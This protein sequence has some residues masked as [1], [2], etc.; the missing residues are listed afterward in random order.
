MTIGSA[1]VE[2]HTYTYSRYQL[3]IEL[4][5]HLDLLICDIRRRQRCCYTWMRIN[6]YVLC[7]CSGVSGYDNN[8]KPC[9]RHIHTHKNMARGTGKHW[10]KTDKLE[11]NSI[12][13]VAELCVFFR[14][15]ILDSKWTLHVSSYLNVLTVVCDSSYCA[16]K[17]SNDE[18]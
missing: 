11:L 3:C 18:E 13:T 8:T 1:L 12:Q 17:R 6:L 10:A 9:K 4:F 16:A 5:A 15:L 7:M 2:V 14:S